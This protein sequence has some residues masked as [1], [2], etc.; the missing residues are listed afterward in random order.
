[1]TLPPGLKLW[2]CP[3]CNHGNVPGTLSGTLGLH[4]NLAGR[5]CIETRAA[6]ARQEEDTRILLVTD[7]GKKVVSISEWGA[8]VIVRAITARR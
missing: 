1:M 5:T 2:H 6:P 7:P 3:L 8:D 4:L